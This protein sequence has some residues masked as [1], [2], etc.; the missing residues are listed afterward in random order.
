MVSSVKGGESRRPLPPFSFLP[1][2]Y[3]YLNFCLLKRPSDGAE[4][5]R[6]FIGSFP[7]MPVAAKAGPSYR[8][9]GDTVSVS[10]VSIRNPTT[11]ES[12]HLD[13]GTQLRTTI[14]HGF[15]IRRLAKDVVDIPVLHL[16]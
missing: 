13:P 14:T 3:L 2:K 7:Q 1:L 5:G 16:K 12:C 6:K 4:G 10:Q 15:K 8:K 9:V 11:G